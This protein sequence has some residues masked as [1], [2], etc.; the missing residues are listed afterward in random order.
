[1]NP[2]KL[3]K[4]KNSDFDDNENINDKINPSL[5]ETVDKIR[6]NNNEN[7]RNYNFLNL[8]IVFIISFV[9]LVILTDTFMHPIKKIFPNIEFL[10]Y[11]LY[12][13]IKDITLFIKDLI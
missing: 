2:L 7:L 13:A 4:K 8:I 1:M 11:N 6:I 12:E 5:E 9:A 3:K 10:L